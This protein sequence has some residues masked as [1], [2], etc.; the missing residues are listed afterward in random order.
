MS[1]QTS[2][3]CRRSNVTITGASSTS[4]AI[5]FLHGLGS[6]QTSWRLLAPA[7]EDRYRVVRLDLVG[8]G[9][10]DATA[11]DYARHGS[12]AAHADDL[13][14]VLQELDLQSII[15]VGHSVSSMIGVLA[16]IKEPARFGKLILLA[17]SPRFINAEGYAG[18]FAQKDIDELLAAMENNYPGWS[19][20]I[21][22]VMMGTERPELVM[23]LTNS[24]MQT[25]PAI[26]QHFAR[27]TF[28][29]DHR[30]DLPLLTTPTLILQCAHDVIAP[31]AVGTYLNENLMDSQLVVIDTPGHCAHLTAPEQTLR[32][33]AFF[34]S[35]PDYS[36]SLN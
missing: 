5:V 24:F 2:S 21:A 18:G 9:Q 7:F 11:Y 19:Q 26:A 15:F 3:A 12:L 27:V 23:E 36:P 6:D 33:I 28:F 31:L 8:A 17:P 29:S 1:T 10:S 14:A 16:A 32:E 34:L 13:L 4:S 35:M 20:G 30:S 25:N 22:P